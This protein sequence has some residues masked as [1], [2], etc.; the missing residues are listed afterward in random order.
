MDGTYLMFFVQEKQHRHG[1][2]LYEWLLHEARRL[3]LKGGSA[4]KAIAGYGRHGVM[5][6][7]HFIELAGDLPVEV[8]FM[9]TPEEADRLLAFLHEEKVSLVYVR[10]PATCGVTGAS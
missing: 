2:L 10:I 1:T 4:F 5:H 3:G 9:A 8:A 7:D 6:A